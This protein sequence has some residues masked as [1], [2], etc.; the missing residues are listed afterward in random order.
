MPL[1]N[2]VLVILCYEPGS[3]PGTGDSSKQERHALT[4]LELISLWDGQANRSTKI[5]S[6]RDEPVKQLKK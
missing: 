3:G 2:E 6:G 4:L 1:P 5:I